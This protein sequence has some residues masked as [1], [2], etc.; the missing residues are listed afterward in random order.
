MS[1]DLGP[2]SLSFICVHLRA[3]A[4]KFPGENKNA[5]DHESEARA[6]ILVEDKR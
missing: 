6:F 1:E 3:S 2:A 4:V 5:P